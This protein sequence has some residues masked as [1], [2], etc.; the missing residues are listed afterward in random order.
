MKLKKI[1]KSK[2]F[3]ISLPISSYNKLEEMAVKDERS[4]NYFVKKALD[5]YLEDIYFSNRAE[6]ILSK[7][8]GKTSTLKEIKE[9]NGL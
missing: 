8:I 6:E 2:T 1:E 5:N 9:E 7:G 3:T 4:K